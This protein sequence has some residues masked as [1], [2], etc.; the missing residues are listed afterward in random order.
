MCR[1]SWK[2]SQNIWTI[3]TVPFQ[4]I[5]CHGQKNYQKESAKF[6]YRRL[7]SSRL[8]MSRYL[9]F[10]VY[11]LSVG[12]RF[13]STVGM[14]NINIFQTSVHY[15]KCLFYK[16]CCFV[17]TCTIS[18]D[19]S[20]KKVHKYTYVIPDHSNPNI[21]QITYYYVSIWLFIKFSIYNICCFRLI[22]GVFCGWN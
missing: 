22:A 5:F 16:K 4:K 10:C 1:I 6:K 14:K 8:K 7:Q 11:L 17:W 20:V 19:F 9:L 15:H 2:R 3:R 21:C 12:L 13:I 18:N